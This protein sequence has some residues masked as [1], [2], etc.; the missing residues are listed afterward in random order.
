MA[1]RLIETREYEKRATDKRICVVDTETDPF[2]EGRVV[3]PF[4]VGFYDGEQYKDFWGDDCIHQFFAWLKTA[5]NEPLLI[6]AHNG[7]GFDFFFMLD[8]MD[9]GSE[10]LIIHGRLTQVYFQGH[11][12]R[13]SFKIIPS[14]LS[15][16]Q[17]DAIDYNK[18]ER[19]CREQHKDEIL[20]YQRKD[21][22]YLYT[23]VERYNNE[24]GCQ[25]TI[26]STAIQY[27][28]HFYGFEK[29][30]ERQDNKF[31]PYYFGGRNQCFEGGV[32]RS[33]KGWKVYDVT[34]MYPYTM[35]A[36]NHPI[37]NIPRVGKSILPNTFFVTWEGTNAGAVPVRADDG[38]LDFTTTK[39][40]YHSTIHEIN[41]GLETGTIRIRRIL[42]TY[43]FD[44]YTDFSL[45]I[46]HFFELRLEAKAA[47]DKVMDL[48]YKLLMN[49]S[50]GKFA[51]DPRKYHDYLFTIGEVPKPYVVKAKDGTEQ[52]V[53]WDMHSSCMD[54]FVWSK[55]AK[56]RFRG[57]R[58]VATAASITGAARAVLLD[59]ITKATR[60]IYCDTDSII[61]EALNADLDG[62]K[63]GTWKLEGEADQAAIAGKKLYCL[64]HSNNRFAMTSDNN[65]QPKPYIPG[66]GWVQKTASKGAKLDPK[67][68]RHVALGGEVTYANPVPHFTLD[69]GADFVT[70]RIT[71]TL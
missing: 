1:S 21:C 70:R 24:F 18:F 13:D 47:G 43:S 49:N 6:Y 51:Q 38:S 28:Q 52:L 33:T 54:S 8:Y 48:F 26:G 50:Y 3:K 16:Y 12:F 19:H 10:P 63:L 37:G 66:V 53:E 56:N 15:A 59:G 62:S 41:A 17:K 45:F 40:I 68:I 61:C 44:A 64:T 11:E 46:D 20:H 2:S 7:G 39:G 14:P 31:R 36:F 34:S 69:G 57:F 67:E 25:L 27:L 71:S 58:N 60:P 32:I 5:Y 35:K 55:P 42:K 29:F 65:P 22:E 30:Q 9:N 23:L 4:S